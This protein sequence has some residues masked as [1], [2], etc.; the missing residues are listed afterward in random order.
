MI[1]ENIYEDE[2]ILVIN[3]PPSI[4][5]SN[6]PS[7]EK[8]IESEIGFKNVLRNGIVH[9]LDKDTSGLL[10]LAKNNI[11]FNNLNE[12]FKNH[13][14]NKIY[15]T[16]VF[17]KTNDRGEIKTYIVRDPKRKQAMKSIDYPTGLERGKLRKAITKY[18]KLKDIQFG[19]EPATLL[20]VS[21][22]T[23][24]THQIRVHML[25]IGHPVLGDKMYFNKTSKKISQQINIKRQLLHS[26][27]IEFIHPTNQKKLSFLC[28]LPNDI[29][30]IIK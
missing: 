16:V 4:E 30:K 13:L 6:G 19:L 26:T 12:Q 21:I 11:S 2:D 25:S 14:I 15:T 7:L 27:K 24:R 20:E 3:K 28:N 5:T 17:G 22:E 29:I 9:R 18:I 1:V 10:I 8:T 23:G